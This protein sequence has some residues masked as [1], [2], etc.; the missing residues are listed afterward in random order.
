MPLNGSGW[1]PTAF[2][3]FAKYFPTSLCTALVET[4]LGLGYLKGLGNPE[5]PHCLACEFVGSSLA[6]WLGAPTLDWSILIV[7]PSDEIPIKDGQRIQP[8]SSFITRAERNAVTW[9][10]DGDELLKLSNS[11]TIT[12]LII[13]DTW[14]R[15]CD[16]YAP[17]GKRRNFDNVLFVREISRR[18]PYRLV[19][20][21]F[22]HAF[23]CGDELTKRL[24]YI[25]YVKDERVYGLFPEFRDH[26]RK[27]V[28]QSCAQKLGTFRSAVANDIVSRVPHE[29]GVSNEVRLAWINLICGRA[30]FLATNIETI[31]SPQLDLQLGDGN[32]A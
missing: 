24:P 18:K 14:F 1:T 8:G 12:E 27:D 5:G 26:L 28:I 3:R 31:L 23:T 19:A 2:R 9:G 11:E 25:E 32:G 6:E 10:G 29:W 22:S 4:D 16:R 13:L 20:M 7:Q 15:N 17:D 21:D 30:H